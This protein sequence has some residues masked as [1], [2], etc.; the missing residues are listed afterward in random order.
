MKHQWMPLFW[1]D[2]L[3]NTMHL[4]AQ[5]VGAYFLLIAHA[6]E[7]G[8]SVPCDKAQQIARVNNLNWKKV[9]ATLEPFFE[10]GLT[11]DGLSSAYY[12]QRVLSEL[13]RA[14]K[15]SKKRKAAAEQMHAQRRA[16]AAFV[17]MQNGC[18]TGDKE[19]KIHSSFPLP[20]AC[21]TGVDNSDTEPDEEKQVAGDKK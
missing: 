14:D 8:G 15:L 10:V 16:F 20:R 4:S 11:A 17:H 3:A 1:G 7:H 13:A 9:R 5:E 19:R 2:F 6:W 12:H 21:A 18:K